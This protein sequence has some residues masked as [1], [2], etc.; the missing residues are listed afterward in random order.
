M[1]YRAISENHL[2]S[3]AYAK[4]KRFVCRSLAVYILNDYAA[5]R[6]RRA[7]P[8]K[9]R[10]NRIGLTVS[11][12]LGGA[13]I[14]NRVKRIIREA[15]RQI[16]KEVGIRTGYLVVIVAREAAVNMKTQNIKRDLLFSL[17]KLN[18][19]RK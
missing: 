5:E 8:E 12:K 15:Y 7:N 19:L 1:K 13:V 3:K 18:M 9:V 14:R 16:D 10:I 2:Y 17:K 4:G 6:L 11:K